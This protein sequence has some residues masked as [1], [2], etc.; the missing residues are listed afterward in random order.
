MHKTIHLSK[1]FICMLDCRRHV[2]VERNCCM[3]LETLIYRH[4]T[5][6]F[7]EYPACLFHQ[8]CWFTKK[9]DSK[10]IGNKY[11]V[12][13]QLPKHPGFRFGKC[14]IEKLWLNKARLF[15]EYL[16]ISHGR[17]CTLLPNFE[18]SSNNA[19]KLVQIIKKKLVW[20]IPGRKVYLKIQFHIFP[21]FY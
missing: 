17:K 21:R 6:L 12:M 20:V 19:K 1:N 5:H 18:K 14:S 11:S 2:K 16:M 8:C 13:D 15:S 10:Y 7:K 3:F 4:D 9:Y